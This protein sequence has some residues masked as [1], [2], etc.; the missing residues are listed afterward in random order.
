MYCLS[1]GDRNQRTGVICGLTFCLVEST[2]LTIEASLTLKMPK[3]PKYT[4]TKNIQV[5][6]LEKSSIGREQTLTKGIMYK[7]RKRDP[8]ETDVPG[9]FRPCF[10]K[11]KRRNPDLRASL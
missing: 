2:L 8:S 6:D 11:P 5:M 1:G 4:K 7:G 3:T 9:I 10:W